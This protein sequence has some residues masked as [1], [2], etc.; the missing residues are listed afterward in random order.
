MKN[1]KIWAFGTAAVMA[2]TLVAAMAVP[3]GTAE[4]GPGGG[5]GGGGPQCGPASL[6]TC[7]MPDGSQQTAA[8]TICDIARF[9][10]RTG[11]SCSR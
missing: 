1:K 6:W 10:R 2:L 11:A 7:D 8:G 9:E 5:P 4:A 3:S